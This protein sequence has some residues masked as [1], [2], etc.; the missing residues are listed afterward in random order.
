M[1]GAASCTAYIIGAHRATPT[2]PILTASRV[3]ITPFE[4]AK[5][6]EMGNG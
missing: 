1:G 3:A 2:D 5:Q 4:A 6:A